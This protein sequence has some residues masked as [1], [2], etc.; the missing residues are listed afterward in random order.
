MQSY[1]FKEECTRNKK[2]GIHRNSTGGE[3]WIRT[4]ETP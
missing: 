4:S 3:D 2:T 1:Q